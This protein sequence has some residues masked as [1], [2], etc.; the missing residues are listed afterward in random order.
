MQIR[1]VK[2]I[3]EA[4]QCNEL[5]TKLINDERKFNPNI[6]N[7]FKV[8]S[9]FENIYDKENNILY[10]AVEDNIVVGY[11]YVKFIPSDNAPEKLSETFIDGLY[12]L[13]EYRNSGIAT[14]LINMAKTW[15]KKLGAKYI[16]LNVLCNNDVAINLYK[17]LEFNDFS[18][19]LKSEL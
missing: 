15:S 1:E 17:K 9:W 6:K 4:K 13:E 11:I 12:V 18:I 16:S 3:E 5:L 10:I 2:T 8:T 7:D 14:S 19:N